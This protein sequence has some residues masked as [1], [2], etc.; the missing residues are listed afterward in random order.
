M[1]S[2]KKDVGLVVSLMGLNGGNVM[3]SNVTNAGTVG[4]SLLARTSLFVNRINSFGS[5]NGF[6]ID[7]PWSN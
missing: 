6:F 2:T 7:I 1:K 3:G 5:R 4:F